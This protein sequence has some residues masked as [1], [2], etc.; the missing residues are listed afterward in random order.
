MITFQKRPKALLLFSGGLD[1]ILAA[2]ILEAEKIKVTPICFESFFFNCNLAKKSAKNLGLK[3]KIIDFSKEHLKVVKNPKYGR[4]SGMNPCIDCHLLMLK[5]AKELMSTS[6]KGYGGSSKTS[7]KGGK[8]EKYDFVATGEVLG[9]RPFSQNQRALNLIEKEAGLEGLILRPLSAKLLTATIP[10]KMGWLKR[11]NLFD[12]E[13]R[14]RKPQFALAKKFKIKDF[15]GPAGGCILTDP[16][17]SQRLKN[18]F[19][20]IP[21]FD[22]N[23]AQFLRKGRNFWEDKFLIIV[24]RNEAENKELKKLKKKR[25]LILEPKNFPG[26]TVLIRSFGKKANSEIR[27]KGK[28]ILIKYSKKL[29]KSPKISENEI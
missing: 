12:I 1:S 6:A 20:K 4:G 27:E 15:P 18:L 22:A 5:K 26:P 24:G 21:D 28:E 23:D 8:K 11:E 9:E 3:L 25:D 16:Q 17:Y 2:K 14:S 13:G 29:A 19:E 7:S 10:E